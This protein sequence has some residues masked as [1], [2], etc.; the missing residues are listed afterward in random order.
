MMVM[1]VSK[2]TWYWRTR[3]WFRV[4][5]EGLGC[6]VIQAELM[7]ERGERG[8]WSIE[9]VGAKDTR[10][11]NVNE[12]DVLT[13]LS[14]LMGFEVHH[15]RILLSAFRFGLQPGGCTNNYKGIITMAH[16]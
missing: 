11:K 14:I 8:E 10:T 5:V 6:S 16:L 1:V 7:E 3:I 12:Q 2:Y 15:Y 13:L 9:N 4:R